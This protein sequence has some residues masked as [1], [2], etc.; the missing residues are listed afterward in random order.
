MDTTSERASCDSFRQ[1]NWRQKEGGK[2]LVVQWAIWL[3]W[4]EM[5]FRGR[6]VSKDGV[7]QDVEGLIASW[8]YHN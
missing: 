3:H 4:N 8:F 7:I 2:I 1:A 6:M 5:L